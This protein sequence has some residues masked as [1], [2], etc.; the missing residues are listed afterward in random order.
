MP[1]PTESEKKAC[2]TAATSISVWKA[3]KSICSMKRTPSIAPGK[4]TERIAVAISKRKRAGIKTLLI[5][6]IPSATPF[7]IMKIHKPRNSSH[8]K[9]GSIESVIKP[10]KKS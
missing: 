4:V 5:F 9:I 2:P 6:S 1:I 10:V 7:K 8:H 3:E